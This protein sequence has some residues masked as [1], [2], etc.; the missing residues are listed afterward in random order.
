[1][2]VFHEADQCDSEQQHYLRD[3]RCKIPVLSV[4]LSYQAPILQC[5][6]GIVE[7]KLGHPGGM[8]GEATGCKL[9]WSTCNVLDAILSAEIL[10]LLTDEPGGIVSDYDSGDATSAERLSQFTDGYS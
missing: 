10:K 1:M 7:H 2:A 4:G 3:E 8:F 9:M 6:P 5:F